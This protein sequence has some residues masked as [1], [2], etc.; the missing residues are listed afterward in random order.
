V[1]SRGYVGS[2]W[3]SAAWAALAKREAGELDEPLDHLGRLGA[4]ELV[5]QAATGER[6]DRRDALMIG[7]D[8]GPGPDWGA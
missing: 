1:K 5:D 6:L 2:G 4:D 3:P 8:T 7:P